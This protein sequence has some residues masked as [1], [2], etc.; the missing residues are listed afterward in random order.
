MVELRTGTRMK[1]LQEGA[2]IELGRLLE[3]VRVQR[4]LKRR[5][6]GGHDLRVETEQ[7]AEGQQRRF[8]QGL[9]QHVDRV[10]EQAAGD[11]LVAFRPEVAHQ[12]VATAALGLGRRKQRQ[13]C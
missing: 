10:G 11:R 6:I 12:L 3:V 1:A 4:R 9:P 8:T 5:Q 13:E 2:P 7:L